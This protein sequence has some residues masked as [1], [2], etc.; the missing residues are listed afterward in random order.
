M[1]SE[2]NSKRTIATSVA[3]VLILISAT[4]GFGGGLVAAQGQLGS[5]ATAFTGET[6]PDAD[7]STVWKAWRII[8]ER[9]VPASVPTSTTTVPRDENQERIYGMIAGLASSLDDPY[10]YFLPPVEQ[11]QFEDDM[12]G[13]FEGVGMEVAV[14]DQILTVVSPLKESPAEKAGI[15]AGDRVIK[16]NGEETRGLDITTAVSK[17]RGPKGSTVKL[18]LVREGWTE[19][20]EISVVRDVINFPIITT[21]M[22]SDGVFVI[23]L[24]TF[25]A[26]APALFKEALQEFNR[27]GSNKLIVDVRGNPGGYLEAAVDMA[28][29]LLPAG[30]VVV[31][32]DYAGHQ[33]NI[34]HR[35]RGYGSLKEGTKLVVL[36][37]KGSASASEILALAL[38]SHG[39]A[40]ILGT[41]TFG[42][43]SV[44]ELVEITKDTSLKIT[45]ARWV[46]PNGEPIPHSGIVPDVEIPVNEDD[47][48]EGIDSQ[49]DKAAEYLRK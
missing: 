1:H 47:V 11:K 34:S 43:G 13:A 10:T 44:Q 30:K 24:A 45:V 42:K 2:S 16:I 8:D 29:W 3:A 40:T 14:R 33:D 20:K 27:S 22:R 4:L 41:T 28:S 31:T 12:S 26:N 32:E 35:S 7:M 36:V 38:K 6:Q 25:T 19:P 37:D 9:F 5:V 39:V 18:L 23:Q 49:L 21:E 48:K 15:K 17:I 46:G